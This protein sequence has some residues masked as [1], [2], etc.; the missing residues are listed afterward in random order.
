[1]NSEAYLITFRTYGTWLPGDARGTV[2]RKNNVPGTPMRGAAPALHRHCLALMPHEATRLG[3]EERL[4]AEA[5]MRAACDH[6]QWRMHRLHVGGEHV[7]SLLSAK[8]SPEQ[9]MGIL[10]AWA[11]RRL[12]EGG[13]FPHQQRIWASGGSTWVLY[14]SEAFSAARDYVAA[15]AT[16]ARTPSGC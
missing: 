5:A 1:M 14:T 4:V 11:T 9:T 6:K 2:H 13:Y 12:R 16:A 15:H 10:K 7:H 3:E 8:E